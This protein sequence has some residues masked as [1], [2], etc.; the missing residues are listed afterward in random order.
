MGEQEWRHIITV[1]LEGAALCDDALAEQIAAAM[2]QLSVPET[3]RDGVRIRY[4]ACCASPASRTS[5][6]FN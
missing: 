1:A 5:W 6:Q 2:Q 3:V 4:L